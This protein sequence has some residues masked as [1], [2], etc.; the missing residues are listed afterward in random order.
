MVFYRGAAREGGTR[1]GCN[2]V[3]VRWIREMRRNVMR[4]GFYRNSSGRQ[5]PTSP[6][7]GFPFAGDKVWSAAASSALM[8]IHLR[9]FRTVI[10]G[11]VWKVS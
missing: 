9:A 4:N 6:D 8:Q 2:L 5:V 3:Y 10:F 7:N 11:E 1:T